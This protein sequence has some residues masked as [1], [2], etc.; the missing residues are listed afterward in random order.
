M[1]IRS[2]L[3]IVSLSIAV[4]LSGCAG[5]SGPDGGATPSTSAAAS[6]DTAVLLDQFVAALCPAVTT[7]YAFNDAWL[8]ETS[9]LE[10]IVTSAAAARDASATA[11]DAVE[12][13]S[14]TWPA[15][16]GADLSLVSELYVTKGA[17]YAAI[18]GAT[19][20]SELVDFE[21]ADAT[22]GNAAAQRIADALGEPNI[23]C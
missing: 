3:I 23:T 7:D 19:S 16:Y 9:S 18:A 15:E 1:L 13:L 2:R 11:V 12:G 10:A 4:A 17:D 5:P 8:D 21:F 22:E 20:L 14:T 6:E